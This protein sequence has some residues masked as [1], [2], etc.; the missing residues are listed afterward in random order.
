MG[1][2]SVSNPIAAEGGTDPEPAES[3]RETIPLTTRTLG[4]VVS[5]LDYEDF[6]RAFTGI[7]KAQAQ[8]L[9]LHAGL[10]IVIT[11]AGPDGAP[12]D[13]ASPIWTNLLGA[14]QGQWRS[15]CRGDA[16]AA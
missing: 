15:A 6:A 3:A 4:R 1:L 12:A 11:I 9:Q 10:T 2:K 8:V 14:L 7:A 16:P 5:L 13:A